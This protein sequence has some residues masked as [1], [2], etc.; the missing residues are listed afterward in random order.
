MTAPVTP[1]PTIA[2]PANDTLAIR[3]AVTILGVLTLV[4]VVSA[5]WLTF[6]DRDAQI[7]GTLASVGFGAFAT[8]ATTRLGGTRAQ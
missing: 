4:A 5:A 7:F 1:E 8:L 2:E 6:V 3:L